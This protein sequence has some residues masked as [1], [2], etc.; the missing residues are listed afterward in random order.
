M[1]NCPGRL[2]GEVKF[3]SFIVSVN[4]K[5]LPVAVDGSST[6]NDRSASEYA[7]TGTCAGTTQSQR[8]ALLHELFGPR[9]EV[10]AR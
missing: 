4:A 5:Q 9:Q 3:I 1:R 10:E 7:G 8:F 2:L 6:G